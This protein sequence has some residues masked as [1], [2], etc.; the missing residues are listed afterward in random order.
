MA[1]W[2]AV[3]ILPELHQWLYLPKIILHTNALPMTLYTAGIIHEG[4]PAYVKK[5]EGSVV[6]LYIFQWSSIKS[7]NHYFD[8]VIQS[9]PF[10]LR[11]SQ[12]NL[13]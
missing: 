10:S 2:S 3:P 11:L 4:Q 13:T 5:Y 9:V 8:G 12:S 6:Y 7:Y 1:Q